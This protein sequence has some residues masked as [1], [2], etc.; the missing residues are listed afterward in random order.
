VLRLPRPDAGYPAGVA[1]T[2]EAET[3][4]ARQQLAMVEARADRDQ[5]ILRAEL[6][7]LVNQ[8]ADYRAAF[9]ISRAGASS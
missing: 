2:A 1:A 9:V 6:D 3:A 4:T 7:R 8:I 5:A